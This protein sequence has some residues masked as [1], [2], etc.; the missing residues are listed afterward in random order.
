MK[1]MV[2]WALP[3]LTICFSIDIQICSCSCVPT[4]LGDECSTFWCTEDIACDIWSRAL[5]NLPWLVWIFQHI[6]SYLRPS[7]CRPSIQ[8]A[9]EKVKE[10]D[11][12]FNVRWYHHLI[13][14]LNI[15]TLSFCRCNVKVV[16]AE[17]DR[18]LRP[19][20]WLIVR[21]SVVST[22]EVQALIESLHWDVRM[23]FSKS[24]EA[25]IAVQKTDWRP[26]STIF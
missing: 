17:M 11:L 3:K 13:E 20:G 1:C 26:E 18:L 10:V 21:D 8:Q 12:H 5:W 14:K 2:W 24:T 15:N 25:L 19:G 4:S 16:I 23:T 9:E 7:S 22:S 6:S